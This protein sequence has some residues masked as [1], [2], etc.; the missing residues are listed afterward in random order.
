LD[1]NEEQDLNYLLIFAKKEM[2]GKKKDIFFMMLNLMNPKYLTVIC[3]VNVKFLL[4]RL[5]LF[6]AGMNLI[7]N[8]AASKGTK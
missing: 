6:F 5:I 8:F 1:A 2:R 7:S 4:N 3:L